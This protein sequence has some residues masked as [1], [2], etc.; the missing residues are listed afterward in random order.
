MLAGARRDKYRELLGLLVRHVRRVE[1][2]NPATRKA[3]WQGCALGAKP[4]SDRR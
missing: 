3:G 2:D 1:A 4:E